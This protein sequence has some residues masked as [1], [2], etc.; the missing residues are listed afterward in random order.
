MRVVIESP[1]M[2]TSEDEETRSKETRRNIKYA[3]ACYHDSLRREEAPYGSHLNFPQPGVLDDNV[4]EDR[5]RG[6]DAGLEITR[7]F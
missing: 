7:D 6:I 4:P 3:R 1:F 2:G 5:K